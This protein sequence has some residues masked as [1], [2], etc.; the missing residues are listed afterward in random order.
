V[1]IVCRDDIFPP[2]HGAAVKI[3]GAAAAESHHVDVC[4]V[5]DDPARY[6]VLRRGVMTPRDYPP[7]ILEHGRPS[8]AAGARLAALGV[9]SADAFLYRP[10]FDPGFAVRLGF[11]A[12]RHRVG[13]FQAE[14]P[15]YAKPCLEVARR[16]GGVT[17]LMQHNVE[18]ERLRELNPR[19]PMRVRHWLR[20]TEIGLCNAAD[21]VVVPSRRDRDALVAAGVA[22]SRVRVIPH[23]V[24][25]EAFRSRDRIDLA[26]RYGI[27]PGTA[28]ITFHGVFRYPPNLEAVR[29]AA[30]ELLPRLGRPAK[31]LAIGLDPPATSLG[32]DVIFTGVVDSL[33]PYLRSAHLAVAPLVRGSGT[34]LKVLDCFAARL[35]LVATSKAVEGLDLTPGRQALIEDEWPAFAQ[36]MRRLLDDRAASRRLARRASAWV[37]TR[38]WSKIAPRYLEAGGIRTRPRA[39]QSR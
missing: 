33:A 3:L 31:L 19:L 21:A 7:L 36:A 32:R 13:L 4:L 8:P 6:Y 29:L 15:A 16:L 17:L 28:V 38:D 23:G 22:A 10:L 1:A 14:F 27:A 26:R 18:F 5:T 30:R 34:R 25:L 9:P 39:A 12:S 2:R 37:R 35:P 24:D 11:V 20:D